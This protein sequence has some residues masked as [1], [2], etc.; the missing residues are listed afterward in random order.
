MSDKLKTQLQLKNP[1][2]LR[3]QSYINGQWL[4]ADDGRSFAVTNPAD[5]S[6][7]ANVAELG[8]VETRRAIEAA[9][10]LGVFV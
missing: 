7:L 2:L 10:H 1:G 5:N 3:E 8:V 9:D 6:L 4:N